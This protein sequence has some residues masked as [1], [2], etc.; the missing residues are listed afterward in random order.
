MVWTQ[1]LIHVEAGKDQRRA[2]TPEKQSGPP[3]FR[4]I[5][6]MK[7]PYRGQILRLRLQSGRTPTLKEMKG[8][9][10]TAR[11]PAGEE[12]TVEVVSFSTIGGKPSQ[13]RFERTGRIDVVAVGDDGAPPIALRWTLTGPGR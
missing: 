1:V 7:A 11:S 2:M 5:D 9:T 4:V 3:V 8:G 10:F 12:A 6:A 13:G